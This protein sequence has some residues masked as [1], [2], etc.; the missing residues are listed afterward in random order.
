MEPLLLSRLLL[1]SVL[2]SVH[3]LSSS[4]SLSFDNPNTVHLHSSLYIFFLMHSTPFAHTPPQH[5]WLHS[6]GFLLLW[7][8]SDWF[9][10]GHM[11]HFSAYRINDSGSGPSSDAFS[12]DGCNKTVLLLC[13]GCGWA[14][15]WG[16]GIFSESLGDVWLLNPIKVLISRCT[17]ISEW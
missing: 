15:P 13:R 8:W 4:V 9:K 14:V 1:C 3:R 2:Y 17:L 7:D 16:R 12:C 10:S 5:D 6:L 11:I